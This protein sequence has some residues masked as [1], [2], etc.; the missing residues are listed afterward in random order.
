MRIGARKV[1]PVLAKTLHWKEISEIPHP[2]S[3]I[4]YIAITNA[5]KNRNKNTMKNNGLKTNTNTDI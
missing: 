2:C 4:H 5:K 1:T 3:E